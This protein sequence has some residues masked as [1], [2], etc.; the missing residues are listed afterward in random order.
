MHESQRNAVIVDAVELT[1]SL[2]NMYGQ[3]ILVQEFSMVGLKNRRD[4]LKSFTVFRTLG[5]LTSRSLAALMALM[6]LDIFQ[7]ILEQL[8]FPKTIS[9]LISQ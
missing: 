1:S 6:E 5:S 9:C 8:M 7:N 2:L 4:F 3:N